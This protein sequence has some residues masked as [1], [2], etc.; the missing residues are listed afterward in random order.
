MKALIL[1]SALAFATPAFAVPPTSET[2][3]GQSCGQG[4]AS[5][6]DDESGGGGSTVNNTNDNTNQNNNANNNTN[7]PSAASNS[8]SNNSSN[9]NNNSSANSSSYAGGSTSSAT[10]GR[11]SVRNQVKNNINIPRQQVAVPD[12]PGPAAPDSVPTLS[13]YFQKDVVGP[14]YGAAIS[15]PLK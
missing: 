8:A 10:G 15:I 6:C 5:F 11:S 13:F 4:N 2:A 9:N 3:P 1:A 7:N 12:L 14:T